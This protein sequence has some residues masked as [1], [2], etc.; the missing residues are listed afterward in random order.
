M[1]KSFGTSHLQMMNG[2]EPLFYNWTGRQKEKPK[3]VDET[4]LWN[5]HTIVQKE[6]FC[7]QSLAFYWWNSKR[8]GYIQIWIHF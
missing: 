2:P 4:H 8:F 7:F 5:I 3:F 1:L 6:V